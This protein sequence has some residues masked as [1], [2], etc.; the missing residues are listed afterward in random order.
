MDS[1]DRGAAVLLQSLTAED[2][3]N[4]GIQIDENATAQLTDCTAQRNGK[5]SG[6][7]GIR[8]FRAA[9]AMLNG[10]IDQ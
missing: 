6:R 2:N 5:N 4:D 1:G 3:A 9:S 7:D 8:V 10:S